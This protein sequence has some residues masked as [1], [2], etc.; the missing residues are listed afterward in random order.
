MNDLS[1]HACS[2]DNTVVVIEGVYIGLLAGA[3]TTGSLCNSADLYCMYYTVVHSAVLYIY[4]HVTC[5]CT[6][7]CVLQLICMFVQHTRGMSGLQLSGAA[8]I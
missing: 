3:K 2:R 6:C 7:T 4:I 5:T 8:I 1:M